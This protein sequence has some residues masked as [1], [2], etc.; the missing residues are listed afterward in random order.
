V[1]GRINIRVI[2][3][4]A[5]DEFAVVDIA[6]VERATRGELAAPG[7]QAVKDNGRDPGI[8]AC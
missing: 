4:D 6:F 5:V 3:K 7:D 1:H 2:S 8:D